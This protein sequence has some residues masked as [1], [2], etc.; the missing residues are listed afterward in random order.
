ME[1]NSFITGKRGISLPFTDFCPVICPDESSFDKTLERIIHY[2]KNAGWEYVEFRSE[3]NLSKYGPAYTFFYTHQLD[4]SKD[5]EEIFRSFKG[6]TRR[7]IK[8]AERSGLAIEFS[9]KLDAV[10]SFYKL[11]CITRKRHGVPPQAFNFFKNIHK[12]V[13]SKAKGTVIT[14]KHEN[15]PVAAAIFFYFGRQAIYK[16]G[17]SDLNYQHLRA[18]NLVMWEAVK[19]FSRKGLEEFHFGRTE[20]EN[21]GL[22]QYKRGWGAIEKKIRYYRYSFREKNFLPAAESEHYMEHIFSRMPIWMLRIVGRLYRHAA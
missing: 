7:N 9:H 17:A 20:P 19:Y 12:H 13:I 4:L 3:E 11:H 2:G 10:N 8:K 1:V 18:N 15:R 16:Y 22:L 5:H 6:S 21:I 14:A